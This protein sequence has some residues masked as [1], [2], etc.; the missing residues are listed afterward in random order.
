MMFIIIY[1]YIYIYKYIF[2]YLYIYIYMPYTEY[3]ILNTIIVKLLNN[4]M[5][6]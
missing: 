4:S 6:I 2:N 5:Q 3:Y 1:I